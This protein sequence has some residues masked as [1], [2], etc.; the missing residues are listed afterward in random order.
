[1][2]L[3]VRAPDSVSDMVHRAFPHR[4]EAGL[5][6]SLRLAQDSDAEM[7]TEWTRAPEVHKFWGGRPLTVDEAL[8]KY[9][10]RRAPD[11][12]SYMVCEGG[13]SVGYVQAWQ[14]AG[15]F[16]LDMFIA[17]EAQGRG[18]GPR[19]ARALATELTGLGWVPLTVDP[20][21]DNT[22]AISA[23][24]AAGFH[25]TGEFGEEDGSPTQVMSF[26]ASGPA[27]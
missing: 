1:M 19:V 5:G 17:V 25:E 6:V 10:G 14:R 18:L 4:V 16:G 15:R 27:G 23:W 8:A 26:S 9:T 11:V 12:A 2:P 22:R 20:A 21:L 3:S 7:I 24:R 13:R